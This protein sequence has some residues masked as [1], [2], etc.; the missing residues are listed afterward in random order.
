MSPAASSVAGAVL[1]PH[2]ARGGPGLVSAKEARDLQA[3]LDMF[4]LGFSDVEEFQRRLVGELGALEVSFCTNA[5]PAA[6]RTRRYCSRTGRFFSHPGKNPTV[7]KLE[8][9]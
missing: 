6:S 2:T 7:L 5:S 1:Q 3:M 8:T 4:S 9:F